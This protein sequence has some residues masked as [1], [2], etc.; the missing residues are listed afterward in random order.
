MFFWFSIKIIQELFTII[1]IINL[2]D[3]LMS[4]IVFFFRIFPPTMWNKNY[5]ELSY[6]ILMSW[7]SILHNFIQ[8]SGNLGASPYCLIILA[9][10]LY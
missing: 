9:G 10:N 6:S 2:F 5:N 4:L 7:Y 1:Q 3:Y 8:D